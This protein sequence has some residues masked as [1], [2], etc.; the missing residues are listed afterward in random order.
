MYILAKNEI[1]ASHLVDID[2]FYREDYF[3][4]CGVNLDLYM[5][6]CQLLLFAFIGHHT[7]PN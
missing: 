3:E 5:L 1:M 7:L 6:V 4:R 2:K